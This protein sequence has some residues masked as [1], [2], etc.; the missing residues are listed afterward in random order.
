MAVY[1]PNSH[2]SLGHVYKSLYMC[3]PCTHLWHKT[4]V[5]MVALLYYS[6]CGYH[7]YSQ[8]LYRAGTML[9]GPKALGSADI[10]HMLGPKKGDLY[11]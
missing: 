3:L 8:C 7:K 1:I 6:I 10:R 4:F 11:R 5:E 2:D 9:A